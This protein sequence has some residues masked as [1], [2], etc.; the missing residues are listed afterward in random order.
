VTIEDPLG[1]ND[2]AGLV[3]LAPEIKKRGVGVV[4]DDFY[5]TQQRPRVALATRCPPDESAFLQF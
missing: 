1:E 4:G 5:V 3:A 2:W